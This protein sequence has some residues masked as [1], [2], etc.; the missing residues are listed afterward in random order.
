MKKALKALKFVGKC[1]AKLI[2]FIL[3]F[4]LVCTIA[5]VSWSM[6]QMS[7]GEVTEA[8]PTVS[9]DFTPA[10]RFV[11]FTD[12]HNQNERVADCIDTAYSLCDND[13]VYKGIDAFFCLGDFTSVGNAPDYDN[14][15]Q[16]INEHVREET[17]IFTILGNHE[18]KSKDSISLFTE[19]FGYEPDGVHEINGFS[20]ICFSSYPHITE[21]TYP[22]SEIK[23]LQNSLEEAEQKNAGKPIFV[24]Q[25]PH[26]FGTVYGS[27]VWCSPQT[28]RVFD[29]HNRVV[30][31]SGHSHFPMNDPRSINQ[32]TYTNIGC[33]G[34]D[35]FEV[36]KSYIVGQHPRGYDTAAQFCIVEADNDGSV[37]VKQF[38]LNSDTFFN[39]YYIENVNDTSTY[40]YTYK[41]M[42]AQDTVPSFPENTTVTASKN[43]DNE[44]I[45]TF[46][47]ADTRFIIHDYKIVIRDENGKK[48][49]S[50]TFLNDYYTLTEDSTTYFGIGTDTLE[51]GKSYTA[52]LTANSA[53]HQKNEPLKVD[54]TATK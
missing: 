37:R 49:Y 40:A 8:L 27:T 21:W 22:H 32:A 31:F 13:E 28:N 24:F 10:V 25:H 20:F 16:A 19:K 52:E 44:W 51:N 12:T 39:D 50:N 47:K 15:I 54:F 9:E 45:L 36:D 42:K 43:E 5:A 3:I 1:F 48:I 46:N 34:M 53:Y 6:I 26:N 18:V 38:D 33:G 11:V 4:A 23:W 29:G 41:N 14:Y 2:C 17:P 35:R 30:C 7:K